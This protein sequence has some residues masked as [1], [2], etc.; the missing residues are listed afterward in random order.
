MA[1]IQKFPITRMN[2]L[3]LISFGQSIIHNIDT[4]ILDKKDFTPHYSKFKATLKD[5]EGCISNTIS[6][7]ITKQIDEL[8]KKRTRIFSSI[9][10]IILAYIN[11]NDSST[12]LSYERLFSLVNSLT[13]TYYVSYFQQTAIISKF[14]NNVKSDVYKN[15]IIKLNLTE[16]ITLLNEINEEYIKLRTIRTDKKSIRNNMIKQTDAKKAFI[17]TYYIL[18]IR[19]NALAVVNGD[20]QYINLFSFW[21]TL[22]D[23]RKNSL[24]LHFGAGKISKPSCGKSNIAD[25]DY[26]PVTNDITCN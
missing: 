24:T 23:E 15:D 11:F 12:L 13:K 9:R 3:D 10:N 22:I 4:L 20:D 16:W 1:Q 19:L 25:P 26:G 21:N 17:S 14:I 8:G 6:T 2:L 18:V 5:M 7:E